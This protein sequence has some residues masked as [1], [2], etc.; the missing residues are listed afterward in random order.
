MALCRLPPLLFMFLLSSVGINLGPVIILSPPVIF[1]FDCRS[2]RFFFLSHSKRHSDVWRPRNKIIYAYGLAQ[3]F[4]CVF[5]PS[6]CCCFSLR[7]GVRTML[8]AEPCLC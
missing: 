8:D 4:K 5:A 6:A 1:V 2:R 7:R 3:A